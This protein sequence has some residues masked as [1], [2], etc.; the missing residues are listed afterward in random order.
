MPAWFILPFTNEIYIFYSKPLTS[1]H[2]DQHWPIASPSSCRAMWA[3]LYYALH[4]MAGKRGSEW[5]GATRYV[6]HL[7]GHTLDWPRPNSE[8]ACS[9]PDM[10]CS[11]PIIHRS[12]PR[13]HW[14]CG[15]SLHSW[16]KGC[17]SDSRTLRRLATHSDVNQGSTMRIPMPQQNRSR[18]RGC[19][20]R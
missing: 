19:E 15:R 9:T 20:G 18:A 8:W 7:P 12:S 17:S 4:I 3:L 5:F 16:L 14:T 13:P 10:P 6:L 11:K 1:L 2:E